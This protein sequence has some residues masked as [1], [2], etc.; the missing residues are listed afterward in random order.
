MN[1]KTK[2]VAAGIAGAALLLGAGGTFALW[3]D[4]EQ[5]TG[6]TITAGTLDVEASELAWYDVSPDGANAQG[7]G[8]PFEWD[9]SWLGNDDVVWDNSDGSGEV[10]TEFYRLD[11]DGTGGG[12]TPIIGHDIDLNTWRTVPGDFVMGQSDVHVRAD[13][14][15]LRAEL[16]VVAPEA[17]GSDL[18]TVLGLRYVVVDMA[19]NV[20]VPAA[21]LDK[22]VSLPIDGSRVNN[23]QVHVIGNFPSGITGQDVMSGINADGVYDG[24]NNVQAVLDSLQV[25]VDQVR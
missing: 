12:T 3:S 8:L 2:G 23:F 24:A 4:A 16:S 20:V 11:T 25:R 14:D 6:G 21:P 18:A 1:K 15:N 10:S 17:Y 19:G 22:P 13:G 5:L 9:A 7:L